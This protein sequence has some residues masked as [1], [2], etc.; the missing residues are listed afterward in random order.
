LKAEER[1][2]QLMEKFK[3]ELMRIEQ[4]R[5]RKDLMKKVEADLNRLDEERLQR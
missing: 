4:R 3:A 5:R 1:R 2:N